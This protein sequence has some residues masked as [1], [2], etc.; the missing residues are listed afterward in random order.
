MKIYTIYKLICKVNNRFYIGS[1]T[2]ESHR[3]SDHFC[4]LRGGYHHNA[5]LQA[6][7]D[8]Y[9]IEAF[10]YEVICKT[11]N[12]DMEYFYTMQYFND[13]LLYNNMAGDTVIRDGHSKRKVVDLT[14]KTAYKSLNSASRATSCNVGNI[15]NCCTHKYKFVTDKKGNKHIFVY[16]SELLNNPYLIDEATDQEY[17]IYLLEKDS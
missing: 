14:T 10:E 12:K 9:G 7:F 4:K 5:E 2:N 17:L 3:K 6:D 13:P 1:T 16:Y 8:K 15:Q 11:T